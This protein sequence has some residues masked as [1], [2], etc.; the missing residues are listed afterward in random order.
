ML[1]WVPGV[2]EIY[3]AGAA[4]FI[5]AQG[6]RAGVPAGVLGVAGALMASRTV[7]TAVP[8]AGALAADLFTTH[9]WAAKLVVAAIDRKL[10]GPIQARDV[11]PARTLAT[12]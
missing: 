1:A 3:S 10:E 12:A 9:R 11:T 6:V 5:L 8:I 4:T 2:G 7:I